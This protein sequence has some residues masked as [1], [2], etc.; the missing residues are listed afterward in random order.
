MRMRRLSQ[1][2]KR[3]A[4]LL[5]RDA[6]ALYLAVRSPDVPWYTKAIGVIVVGY[7]LSPLDLIPDF[8][9]VLGLIDDLLIVPAGI[10]LVVRLIPPPVLERCRA[11]AAQRLAGMRHVSRLAAVVVVVAWISLFALL[12]WLVVS[13]LVR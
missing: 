1:R 12:A 10:A 5:K 13:R 3:Q 11:Q 8:I 7:L 2:L 9:P 6:Y 4:Q